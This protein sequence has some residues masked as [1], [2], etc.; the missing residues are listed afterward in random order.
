LKDHN[1]R[2]AEIFKC[3]GEKALNDKLTELKIESET[4]YC[5]F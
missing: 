1:F 5:P 2:A 4:E 3:A